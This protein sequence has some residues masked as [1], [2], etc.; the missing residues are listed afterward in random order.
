MDKWGTWWMY[1][2]WRLQ[3]KRN[4]QP[5]TFMMTK[6]DFGRITVRLPGWQEEGWVMQGEGPCWSRA[7]KRENLMTDRYWGWDYPQ[8]QCARPCFS[9]G[10][11]A[12]QG[13]GFTLIVEGATLPD[14]RDLWWLWTVASPFVNSHSSAVL[15]GLREAYVECEPCSSAWLMAS[16]EGCISTTCLFA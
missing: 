12:L 11:T 9:R 10:S 6:V 15:L 7:S 1:E 4:I 8:S 16:T 5:F 2:A 3:R 14:S 13:R